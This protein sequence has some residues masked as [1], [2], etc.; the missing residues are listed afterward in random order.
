MKQLKLTLALLAGLAA[1]SLTTTAY[2]ADKDV[3]ITGT[4]LCAKCALHKSDKCETVLQTTKD[5]TMVTYWL[6]GK[7]AKD[8]HHNICSSDKGEQVTVTGTVKEK[9]GKE[10]L[11]VAKIEAKK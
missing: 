5:G 6:T 9:D 11:K 3:T 7:E 10:M 1:A 2:A 4:A 8:F